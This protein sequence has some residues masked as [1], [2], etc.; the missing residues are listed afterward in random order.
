LTN[1]QLAE[2]YAAIASGSKRYAIAAAAKLDVEIKELSRLSHVLL[3]K[4]RAMTVKDIAESIRRSALM[5][6]RP[7]EVAYVDYIGLI[8]GHGAKRYER[9]SAIA[10]DL[11]TMAV[12]EKVVLV[13]TSQVHRG[14]GDKPVPPE[15]HS[16][17][18]SGSIEQSSQ[19][20]LG[21]WRSETDDRDM[22]IKIL[23]ATNGRAGAT[24]NCRFD[25]SVG[26]IQEREFADEG[27]RD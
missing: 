1:E 20:I 16:A 10:E 7:V 3:C 6:G 14:E 24:L 9:V 5:F 21:A 12:E 22:F 18:D 15:L 25:G 4:K 19:L 8:K 13:C 2:R 11:K 26:T 23:K 27:N 17:R